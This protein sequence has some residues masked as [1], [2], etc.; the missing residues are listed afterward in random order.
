MRSRLTDLLRSIPLRTQLTAWNAAVVIVTMAA[1]LFAVRLAARS[2]LHADADAELRAAAQ[3]VALAVR[4]LDPDEAAVVAEMRRKAESNEQ[5]GLFMHLLTEDG[6]SV[7]SSDHCPESVVQ[8]PPRALD[9]LENVVQ[10]GP[11]RYVR[12]RIDRAAGPAYHV[13]VG[14]YTAR[15]DDTLSHLLR[16]LVLV[17]SVLSLVAPLVAYW[18]AVRATRPMATMLRTAERLSPTRLG[19]RLQVRGTSDEL[20]LLARTINGLLDSVARHVDRQEQF[21]ADAAHELRG[22]LAALQGSMEV[23]IARDDLPQDQQDAL[24]DM[25]EAA[26]H[27]SKVANDLLVLAESAGSSKPAQRVTTDLTAIAHQAVGMFSGA[28]EERGVSLSVG[29]TGPVAARIDP[30]DLRRLLSNLLDNAIRFTP[31]GGRVE[32]L[33]TTAVESTTLTVSDTGAGIAQGDL[34]HV[35]DRFFKADPART[36]GSGH[37]SGGLGLSICRSI[38][39]SCGGTIA[40]TSRVGEGTT[41]TVRLPSVS[42]SG[43]VAPHQERTA[44]VRQTALPA[45]R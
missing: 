34:D 15:L 45:A 25:L 26:R 16:I 43:S 27:L 31:P 14:T 42:P 39:E 19:D 13:R 9:R 8:F 24:S 21:V 22:P 33:V 6:R 41:V 28:A 32:V 37:R 17:G 12:L 35:F 20:D 36:H 29:A 23:A 11:F 30:I 38:A 5:R 18:L 4:D 1:S 7:W 10:L 3:E 2:A 40:I 44:P